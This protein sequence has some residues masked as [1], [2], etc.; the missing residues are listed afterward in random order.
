MARRNISPRGWDATE[1]AYYGSGM[2]TSPDDRSNYG[3]EEPD[4]FA[5]LT[6][7]PTRRF[8][9]TQ[10]G[11]ELSKWSLKSGTGGRSVEDVY[12]PGTLPGLGSTTTYLHAQGMVGFDW[13]TSEGYT[14]RGGF[15][16]VTAHDYTDQDDRLGFRR[17]DYEVIQHVPILRENWV[18]SFHGVAKTTIDDEDVVPYFLMPSLGSG[19]TLRAYSSWRFRDRHS[20]LMSGEFRWMPSL[21]LDV[22]LFYDAGKVAGQRSDL[23][24]SGLHHDWGLGFR[25]HGPLVTPLRIE[26]AHGREG[27]HLVFSGAAAF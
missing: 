26:I 23:N 9:V 25:F 8:L 14:R 27:L 11:L 19:S 6:V 21:F 2:D 24:L 4:G 5:L 10:G 7:R 3:F 18:L 20:L 17:I 22:A 13:R 16:G 1:V 12:T 15:Y